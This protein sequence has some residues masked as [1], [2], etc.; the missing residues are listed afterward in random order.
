[1]TTEIFLEISEGPAENKETTEST[2]ETKAPETE[3]TQAAKK[4]PISFALPQRDTAYTAQILREGQHYLEV[5]ITPG[6]ELLN[7]TVEGS[8]TMQF[9]LVIDGAVYSSQSVEF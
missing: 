2:Q 4:V 8:G 6:T 3:P 9:S 1:M 7:L 5:S